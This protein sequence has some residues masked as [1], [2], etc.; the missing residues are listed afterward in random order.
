MLIFEWIAGVLVV[1]VLLAGVA[2]RLGA[3]FPAFLAIGGVALTFV[4]QV[5]R[6]G[7]DPD[8]ALALFLAPVLLDAA[9]DTSLRDLKRNWMPVAGLVVGAVGVT[10][11]AVA[12]VARWLVPDMPLAAGIVLGAIVAPPDAV[13]ALSVLAHVRLPHRLVTILKGESLFNDASSLL[14]YR[15]A[16]GAVATGSFSVAEVAPTFLIGVVGGLVAG[17]VLAMLYVRLM[18]RVTDPPSAVV[19]QFVATFGL[20]IAAERV[21]VSGVLTVVSFGLTVSRLSPQTMPAHL[22]VTSNTVWETAVF[23]LNVLA[24]VV[25]GLQIGP[26]LEGLSPAERS[27][28]A[29]VAA[30]VF[31]TTVVVRLAWVLGAR[32]AA[33]LWHRLAGPARS[34]LFWPAPIGLRSGTTV[35]WCGMRGVVTIALALAL[36]GD[37]PHRD[38]VVLTAFCVVLGTLVIQGLTLRPL[39]AWFSLGDDD[40]VGIEIGRA[41]AAAYRAARD[42]LADDRSPHAEALRREFDAVLREAEAH[43]EGL[44]PASLPA[45]GLRR[46]A[47]EAARAVILDLRERDEIGDDAYLRLEEELDWAELSATPREEVS[48]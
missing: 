34:R 16:L 10:T 17:P 47:V 9:Y 22:R 19:L 14:I 35:A 45:D 46:R 4:P 33:R 28:Y 41:R 38:L 11:V 26:I 48:P 12:L 8:L 25:I 23:V 2:R 40:P 32:A 30:A 20:W 44:A 31:G 42:S 37:F 21:E 3:P 5:P 36:P 13:A 24:F 7:L 29:L 27:H 15:L 6:P 18:R 43:D 39:L 1:A